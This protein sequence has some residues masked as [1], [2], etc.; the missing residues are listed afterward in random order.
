[1][2]YFEY[3]ASFKSLCKFAATFYVNLRPNLKFW[4]NPQRPGPHKLNLKDLFVHNF[5]TLILKKKNENL[6]VSNFQNLDYN[7][8]VDHFCRTHAQYHFY[9]H[10]VSRNLNIILLANLSK[11]K[12]NVE[13]HK[14]IFQQA[15]TKTWKVFD[16]CYLM[17]SEKRSFFYCLIWKENENQK[18]N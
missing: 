10:I 4:S 14:I 7:H 6:L 1:M 3:F 15:R 11:C 17:V 18:I 8:K 12:N 9:K 2:C 13:W 16:H 5:A